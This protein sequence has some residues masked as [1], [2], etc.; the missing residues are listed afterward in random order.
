M[1]HA[2]VAAGRRPLNLRHHAKLPNS[3]CGV[4]DI[5]GLEQLSAILNMPNAVGINRVFQPIR[6]IGRCPVLLPVAPT[7]HE[8]HVA[9]IG[10]VANNSIV[11]GQINSVPIVQD[12]ICRMRN[13]NGFKGAHAAHPFGKVSRKLCSA[14]Q[15]WICH[16]RHREMQWAGRRD[17]PAD[18]LA[19]DS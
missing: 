8:D 9:R 1:I 17:H 7:V 12:D 4:E 11:P 2:L 10:D 16:G 14:A 3:A 6:K 13:R 18:C 5:E 15:A 19:A